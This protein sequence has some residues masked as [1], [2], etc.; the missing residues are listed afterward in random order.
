MEH[1]LTLTLS[2]EIFLPLV[3]DALRQGRKLEDLAVERLA[4][5][6]L[7]PHGHEP[8]AKGSLVEL[9]GSV[10]LGHPTG[11]D[12]ESIEL[13]TVAHAQAKARLKQFAGAVNSGDPHSAD[14]ER[15]DA[16]LAREYANTH[17]TKD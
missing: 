14:N 2:E 3:E 11:L 16:D 15:I 4:S 5:T 8:A 6:V 1:Q 12:N 13:S 9:F 10:S 7:K 17:E